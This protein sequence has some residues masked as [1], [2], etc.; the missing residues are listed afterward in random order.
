MKL[1]INQIPSRHQNETHA[2][3]ITKFSGK[4]NVV[5][6]IEDLEARFFLQPYSHD[7]DRKKVIVAIENLCG[8][9]DDLTS[10]A[11]K[12]WARLEVRLNPHL[13]DNW[14]AFPDRLRLRYQN[15]A[16]RQKKVEERQ[17]LIQKGNTVQ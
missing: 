12:E 17:N 3:Q 8:A 2:S 16:L 15:T 9:E 1:L 11:P 4:T 13:K 5:Q 6:Y 10:N 7:T 14:T